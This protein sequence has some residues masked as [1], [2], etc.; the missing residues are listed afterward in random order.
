MGIKNLKQFLKK[1]INSFETFEKNV[2][3]KTFENKKLLLDASLYVFM[4]K[5]ISKNSNTIFEEMF[6]NLFASMKKANILIFVV[7]DGESPK[8]KNDEK[9]KRREKKRSAQE[10]IET[11]EK[12]LEIYKN[13]EI[14]NKTL[15]EVIKK[16]NSSI[17]LPSRIK[18]EESKKIIIKKVNEYISKQKNNLIQISKADFET[19]EELCSIFGIPILYAPGEAE[20]FCSYL[21]KNNFADGVITKD[22]DVLACSTPCI[23]TKINL[24]KYFFSVLNMNEVLKELDFN[25]EEMLDFCIMCGTDYNKNIKGVGPVKSYN[26]IK[27][28]KNLDVIEKTE[29][30]NISSLNYKI[31]RNLFSCSDLKKEIILEEE[32]KINFEKLEEFIRNKKIKRNFNFKSIS[33]C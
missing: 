25:E 2:S 21:I 20:I 15:E 14:L 28:Y 16:I 17:I 6:I 26:L 27:K 10:K 30:I 29:K 9:E 1:K 31:V 24:D 12:E 3:F 5:S 32:K 8:E 7:F 33:D 22:T 11:I 4:Y 19:V 18:E 23:I 13:T